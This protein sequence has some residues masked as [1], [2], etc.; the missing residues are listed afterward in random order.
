MLLSTRAGGLGLNLTSADTV[1][2]FDSDWNP[3]NDIQVKLIDFFIY[4]SKTFPDIAC[5]IV[6][7]LSR[8]LSGSASVTFTLFLAV[9]SQAQARA[10]RIGQTRAVMVYRLITT[11]TYEMHMFHKA[12]LKLG[13]DKAVLAHAKNEAEKEAADARGDEPVDPRKDRSLPV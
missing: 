3:H 13:L 12:S 2:I 8:F 1:I 10:H 6:S 5:I 4:C 11:K 9:T 7:S